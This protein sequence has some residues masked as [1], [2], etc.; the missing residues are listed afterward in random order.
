MR[1]RPC[2]AALGLLVLT[3]AGCAVIDEP[4]PGTPGLGLLRDGQSRLVAGAGVFDAYAESTPSTES[5]RTTVLQGDLRSG[6]RWLG[7]APAGGVLVNGGGG[8]YGFAGAYADFAIGYM[9]VTPLLGY[10]VYQ[11]NGGKD[12]GG[13]L[14]VRTEVDIAYVRADGIR[15]GL[16]WG[17][18][19]NA[20]IYE[21]NPSQEDFML[22]L[23]VPF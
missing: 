12:L 2:R 11:R 4:P 18:L 7:L 20:Y 1:Y 8:I 16:R 21:D 15:V 17:H 14:L 22:T 23:A 6:R 10:G 13:L 9:M 19:S 5:D 3:L